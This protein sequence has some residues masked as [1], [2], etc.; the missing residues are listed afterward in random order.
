MFEHR[1]QPLLPRPLWLRRLARS[2]ALAGAIVVA[3]LGIGMLGYHYAGG[4]AWLDATL[5]AAMILA[6]MGPVDRLETSAAKLFAIGYAL[7]SGIVFLGSAAVLVAPWIH[8][9]LHIVH[10]EVEDDDK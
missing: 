1:S 2:T 9:L 5:N 10:A 6:G 4:L 3:G 7:F 8:R